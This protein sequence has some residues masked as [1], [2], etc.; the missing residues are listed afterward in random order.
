MAAVPDTDLDKTVQWFDK[1]MISERAIMFFL[2]SH[3]HE[4]LGQMIA[5]ARS[6]GVTPPWSVKE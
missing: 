5:Y 4:H 2:A 6:N 1:S 3:N